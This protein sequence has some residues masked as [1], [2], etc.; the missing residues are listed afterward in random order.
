VV[1][2]VKTLTSKNDGGCMLFTLAW[3]V[4]LIVAASLTRST[5]AISA[6]PR[7]SRR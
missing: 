6:A 1:L 4:L 3:A 2:A 7:A 5:S